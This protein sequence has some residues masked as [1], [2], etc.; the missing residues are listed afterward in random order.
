MAE[1]EDALVLGTNEE[2]RGGSSPSIRIWVCSS[3]VEHRAFNLVAVGSSPITLNRVNHAIFMIKS[4]KI[5]YEKINFEVIIQGSLNKENS[6]FKKW[7]LLS[8]LFPGV[9]FTYKID[10]RPLFGRLRGY[11]EIKR[12]KTLRRN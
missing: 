2:I 9:N 1:L 5:L 10:S 3:V 7:R 12:Q 6:P 4:L 11:F 8:F